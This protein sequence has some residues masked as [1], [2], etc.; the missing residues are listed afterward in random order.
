MKSAGTRRLFGLMFFG[1]GLLGITVIA[2]RPADIPVEKG[3]SVL[4]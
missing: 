4:L 1:S 3:R 2:A